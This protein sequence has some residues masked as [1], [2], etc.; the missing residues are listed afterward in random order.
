MQPPQPLGIAQTINLAKP[1]KIAELANLTNCKIGRVIVNAN[2]TKVR[3][4]PSS[5]LWPADTL[6]PITSF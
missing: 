2:G 4:L 6:L 5:L 3:I 1:I